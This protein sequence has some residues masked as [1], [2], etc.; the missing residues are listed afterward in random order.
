M[1][2]A[3]PSQCAPQMLLYLPQP[4]A[5]VTHHPRSAHSW[6]ICG[7][8]LTECGDDLTKRA[9]DLAQC[10]ADLPACRGHL[11]VRRDDRSVVRR[12]SCHALHVTDPGAEATIPNETAQ[13]S[14]MLR[15]PLRAVSRP[16]AMHDVTV[17]PAE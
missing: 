1:C 7:A 3:N 13:H 6:P 12:S 17:P 8:D 16:V 11:S 4:L 15:R 10:R 2:R 14:M 5:C 9:D